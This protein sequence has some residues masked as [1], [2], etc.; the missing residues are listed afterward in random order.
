MMEDY[1]TWYKDEELTIKFDRYPM[2]VER[3]PLPSMTSFEKKS[4]TLSLNP[5]GS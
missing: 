1:I 2:V 4:V 3:Y 5:N